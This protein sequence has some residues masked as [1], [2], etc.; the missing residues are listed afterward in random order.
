M[1]LHT[2]KA[3][4]GRDVVANG[5]FAHLTEDAVLDKVAKPSWVVWAD[6]SR[7]R[8]L[9]RVVACTCPVVRALLASSGVEPHSWWLAIARAIA[10]LRDSV[11]ELTTLPPFDEHTRE[12]WLQFVA[13]DKPRWRQ[14]LKKYMS[15]DV[16]RR[17]E[18]L[19]TLEVPDDPRP[20]PEILYEMYTCTTCQKQ[21]ST[22]RGLLSHR[23]QAHGQES[24]LA[25]RVGTNRCYACN[26]EYSSRV[27]H[28]AHLSGNLRCALA[29]MI[30]CP[31]LSEAELKAAKAVKVF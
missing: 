31:R 16:L 18:R 2:W 6:V 8:L 15:N 19:I 29:T 13:L 26:G 21:C 11:D 17:H 28:L 24:A 5:Q 3:C 14:L 20:V 4:I 30:H 10:R 25:V 22:Y 12:I 27:A 9:I 7:L 1:Y 23:R